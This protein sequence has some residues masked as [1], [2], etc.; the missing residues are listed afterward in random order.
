MC[1]C[2]YVFDRVVWDVVGW[3]ECMLA[4][5]AAQLRTVHARLFLNGATVHACV[6]FEAVTVG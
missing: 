2:R 1:L 5:W 6:M 3:F 4:S